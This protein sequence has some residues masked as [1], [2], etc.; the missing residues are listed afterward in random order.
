MKGSMGDFMA[1]SFDLKKIFLFQDLDAEEMKA[2]NGLCKEVVYMN[3]QDIF[4][5]GSKAEC[6]Y[7]IAH[8]AVKITHPTQDGEEMGIKILATGSHFG[9][10]SFIDRGSRSA[11]AQAGETTTLIEISY[12]A[13]EQL[14]EQNLKIGMKVY[15]S[16]AVYL[17]HRLR[18]TTE[19]LGSLRELKLRQ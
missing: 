7:L 10:M 9:E 19:D 15:R 13:L 6:M 18:A 2:V 8:G 11:T 17:S 4:M 16:F 5:K 12:K 3:G 1:E 14:M